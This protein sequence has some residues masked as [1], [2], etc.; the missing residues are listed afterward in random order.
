MGLVAR[1]KH[2]QSK[3]RL[4]TVYSKRVSDDEFDL[5]RRGELAADG[6]PYPW[7]VDFHNAGGEFRQRALISGN[8]TGKTETCAAE[9]AIHATGLYP[10]WW[11]GLRIKHPIECLIACESNEM[12]RDIQQKKLYGEFELESTEP[13]GTGWVPKD[14]ILGWDNRVC[15]LKGVY[16]KVQVRH[17]SGG[18]S[19]IHQKSYEQGYTKFQGVQYD[20]TWLDEEPDDIKIFSEVL[21]RL[22]ARKGHLLLSRTPLFGMTDLIDHFLGDSPGVYSANVTWDDA[23]HLDKQTKEELLKSIPPHERDARTKGIPMMGEGAIFPI[24]DE[25]IW[26]EQFHAPDHWRFLAAMD[27]GVEHP[28]ACVW[29]AWNMESD[30]VYVTDCYRKGRSQSDPQSTTVANHASAIKARDPNN[31]IPVAWPH[32]GIREERVGGGINLKTLYEDQGVNMLPKH[33]RYEENDKKGAGAGVMSVERGLLEMYQRMVDGRLKVFKHLNDWFEEKRVYHRK[34]GKIV[35]RKDDLLSAT[36]IGLMMLR[37]ARPRVFRQREVF[38][39]EQKTNP[40]M[41]FTNRRA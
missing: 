40:L 10:D 24:S 36:R 19:V 13:D 20:L 4:H 22:I 29:L 34:D 31:L 39:G 8:Q 23:P 14:R 25:D 2:A 17:A 9:V 3:N 1:I 18:V 32:D 33:A 38:H 37:Y 21:M 28:T 5:M 35:P 12:T 30:V 7:Q 15:G 16:D 26:C 11:K 27:F 41:A 6:R